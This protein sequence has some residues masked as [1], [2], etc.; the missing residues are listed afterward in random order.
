MQT[1]ARR[2]PST[3]RKRRKE[4]FQVRLLH[5]SLHLST[6]LYTSLHLSTPLH[7]SLHLSTPLYT[8]PHLSTP[9]YCI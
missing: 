3:R 6:P 9:L 5:T 8:S 1:A 2:N 4:P 7:T